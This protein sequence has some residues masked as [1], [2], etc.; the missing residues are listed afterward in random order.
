MSKLFCF[1]VD[2]SQSGKLIFLTFCMFSFQ[3]SC[4]FYCLVVL[5][6]LIS[7]QTW[8]L[9]STTFFNL[10]SVENR[11]ENDNLITISRLLSIGK[12]FFIIILNKVSPSHHHTYSSYL[13]FYLL[14]I[15]VH[16]YLTSTT[17]NSLNRQVSKFLEHLLAIPSFKI[18]N[19]IYQHIKNSCICISSIKKVS[20]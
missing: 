8:L 12:A 18:A 10:F 19:K 16:L 15:F 3:C 9:M 2:R 4:C 11:N 1:P 20:I 13:Y 6:T 5:A 7:Y 17:I 14:S